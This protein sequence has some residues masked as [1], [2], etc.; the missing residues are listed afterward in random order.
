MLPEK[1]LGQY[2]GP[3]QIEAILGSGGMAVVYRA[4]RADSETV[5]LKVLF[6][7]PEA[8]RELRL[9]FERE[10]HTAARLRH[11]AIVRILD[12]GQSDGYAYLAMPMIEGQ[13]LADR[14]RQAD[15]LSEA[16]ATEI[17]W[18]MADALAYAHSQ[19]VVHRDIKPSNIL[20]TRDGRAWLTDFGVAQALDDPGLTR[21]GQTVGTPAYMSPEQASG[22]QPVDGRTDLYALGVVLYQMVTGRT[23]FQGPT[24]RILHAHLY[25]PP[26]PP[27]T[28]APVSPAMEA[29]IMRA[30]AKEPS[31][32][33]Q[34]GALMAQALANLSDQTSTHALL[35]SPIKLAGRSAR[36]PRWLW[37]VGGIVIVA[38]G[39]WQWLGQQA[40]TPIASLEAS[41][42]PTF[43]PTILLPSPTVM[44]S[45]TNTP[46]QTPSPTLIPLTLP[47]P[48]MTASP[49]SSPVPTL[50]PAPPPTDT[51]T[52]LPSPTPCP[53]PAA[54]E[55]T[56][57]LANES[58]RQ[59]LG[60]SRAEAGNTPSAW[61]PFERGAMLWQ[62]NTN[63][64]YILGSD[65][66]WRS[67][68][69]KWREGDLDFDPNLAAPA[70]LYQPVRGFGLVWREQ[71]GVREE[72]GWATREEHGFMALLQ[73]FAGG[74][75]WQDAEGNRFFIL[76][77][78]GSYE[79]EE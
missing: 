58:L 72:L 7:P 35:H 56:E 24:P 77:T 36:R 71:S 6:P 5:A 15:P 3:Y 2:L 75:I 38:V 9:R 18:Q 46:T 1:L 73:E 4:R 54:S 51:P 43:T 65:N 30:L 67:I 52:P 32:R 61:Q 8:S 19:G 42:T 63:L 20:I 33:F 50:V 69:D 28:I 60:C 48:T 10:A 79:I 68:G 22:D 12:A 44:P 64:I 70:G 26:P 11:P 45:L 57:L 17:A 62:A 29:I 21:T 78:D 27:S 66:R 23:P 55:F 39:V 13:T 47:T 74:L 34:N 16:E 76:F 59:Q 31:Q 49:T 41:P 40:V 53:Q 37:L 25:E 14:L